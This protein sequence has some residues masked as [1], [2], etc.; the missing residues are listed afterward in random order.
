MEVQVSH[1]I[2]AEISSANRIWKD[3]GGRRKNIKGTERA[4]RGG[5]TG[6]G[7]LPGSYPYACVNSTAPECSSVYGIP[8]K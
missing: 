1:C 4:K 3:K 6:S 5:D 8:Q 7:M 2:C